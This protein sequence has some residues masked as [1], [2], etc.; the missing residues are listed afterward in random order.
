[1]GPRRGRAAG[2]RHTDRRSCG[3]AL[4]T[5]H[6]A[7]QAARTGVALAGRVGEASGEPRAGAA[8]GANIRAEKL[9]KR[10]GGESREPAPRIRSGAN[11]LQPYS[12]VSLKGESRAPAP[13]GATNA[14]RHRRR[15]PRPMSAPVEAPAHICRQRRRAPPQRLTIC[16]ARLETPQR[17]TILMARLEARAGDAPAGGYRPALR[18]IWRHGAPHAHRLALRSQFTD[19]AVTGH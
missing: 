17:L 13:R 4:G 9:Q 12:A 8:S 15:R 2:C 18:T 7:V 11:I 19:L 10:R 6:S 14:H 1:M 5:L 3:S 16:M